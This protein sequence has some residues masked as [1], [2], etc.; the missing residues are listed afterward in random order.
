MRRKGEDGASKT[1]GLLAGV[2]SEKSQCVEDINAYS[3]FTSPQE[4]TEL[5]RCDTGQLHLMLIMKRCV[6]M[7]A[8]SLV[9]QITY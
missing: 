3:G 9:N 1:S 4:G 8:Q 5:R 2:K 7:C 6:C